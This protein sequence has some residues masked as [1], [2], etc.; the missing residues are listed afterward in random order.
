MRR[1]YNDPRLVG[2]ANVVCGVCSES[3][4]RPTG[5]LCEMLPSGRWKIEVHCTRCG[6]SSLVWA[7]DDPLVRRVLHDR[8][9]ARETGSR[10]ISGEIGGDAL[11]RPAPPEPVDPP[12]PPP[13][14]R[15]RESSSPL[16]VALRREF[17]LR[18]GHDGAF[19]HEEVPTSATMHSPQMRRTTLAPETLAP[20][21]RLFA[22]LPPDLPDEV[23]RGARKIAIEFQGV[24]R[25][26]VH[27]NQRGTSRDFGSDPRVTK[28]VI[29]LVDGLH[30]LV[31][32]IDAGGL[33]PT[34]PESGEPRMFP[35]ADDLVR[36]T[37][38]ARV[39]S[40]HDWD[41]PRANTSV[42][43]IWVSA[44][45]KLEDRTLRTDTS[46]PIQVH[47]TSG[48]LAP[49]AARRLFDALLALSPSR[50]RPNI[51]FVRSS[52]HLDRTHEHTFAYF[53]GTRVH[54]TTFVFGSERGIGTVL[55]DTPPT[56]AESTAFKLLFELKVP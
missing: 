7:S 8:V 25:L 53:D 49:A 31:T 13:L 55:G 36:G 38:A 29:D 42:H 18:V 2:A 9:A 39:T 34:W 35:G 37:V 23:G 22:K 5:K 56:D 12:G 20:L 30:A 41:G 46:P 3:G 11:P 45:G 54:H 4:A 27:S 17:N 1:D 32:W 47:T 28:P 15:V 44:S 19:I 21:R 6:Q 40:T 10:A 52:N 14:L 50:F 26:V 33:M 43:E 24:R 48:T 16:A 51:G